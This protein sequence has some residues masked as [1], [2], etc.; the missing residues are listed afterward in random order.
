[1]DIL[2]RKF[3][4]VGFIDMT[5]YVRNMYM[6]RDGTVCLAMR[7]VMIKLMDVTNQIVTEA[8]DTCQKL[9]RIC[10]QEH[11]DEKSLVFEESSD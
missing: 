11:S 7:T 8:N 6:M 1:M 3:T 2:G 5:E 4:A 10:I 9:L